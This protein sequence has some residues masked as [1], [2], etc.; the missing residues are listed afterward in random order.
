MGL[1]VAVF[2]SDRHRSIA[3]WIRECRKDT[4]HYYDIWH[5]AKSIT[6]KLLKASKEKGCEVIRYWIPGIKKHLYWCATSTKAGFEALILAKWMSFLR[7]VANKH[8]DHP[9]ALYKECNHG[10][11]ARRKWI[12]IGT[13]LTRYEF[14]S[15]YIYSGLYDKKS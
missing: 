2:I 9:N 6:K 3:K 8:S 10:Q 14:F 5:V 11:L 7:H 13:N 15:Y 4:S 12:K 1:P